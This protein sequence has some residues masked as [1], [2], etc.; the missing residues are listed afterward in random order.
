MMEPSKANHD[1]RV[2]QWNVEDSK[3]DP[4]SRGKLGMYGLMDG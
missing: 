2:T 1:R 4:L 3:G